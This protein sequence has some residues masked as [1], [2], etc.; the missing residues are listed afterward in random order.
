MSSRRNPI[1]TMSPRGSAGNSGQVCGLA[2]VPAGAVLCW[3]RYGRPHQRSAY[4]LGRGA[5]RPGR[6]AYR[7]G[8]LPRP[9]NAGTAPSPATAT[10]SASAGR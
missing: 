6:G 5:Y 8:R 4:R 2:G 10:I 7:P 9:L 1:T 3:H